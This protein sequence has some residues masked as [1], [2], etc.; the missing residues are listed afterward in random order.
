MVQ[1]TQRADAQ[2]RRTTVH[3]ESSDGAS[4]VRYVL[5]KGVN[6]HLVVRRRPRASP[7]RL[8]LCPS[9]YSSP[10]HAQPLPDGHHWLSICDDGKGMG[11]STIEWGLLSRGPAERP[12]CYTC[13][14]WD[15]RLVA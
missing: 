15:A 12:V 14:C 13:A 7:P 3:G 5:G 6:E 8:S 2:R 4:L 11:K 9:F 10:S 1:G